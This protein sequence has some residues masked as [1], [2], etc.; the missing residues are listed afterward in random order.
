M[1]KIVDIELRGVPLK[2][3]VTQIEEC[4]CRLKEAVHRDVRELHGNLKQ[5]EKDI[6]AAKEEIRN[7][8]E[9]A[10]KETA[11]DWQGNSNWPFILRVAIDSISSILAKIVPRAF[12]LGVGGFYKDLAKLKGIAEVRESLREA[13][14]GSKERHFWE[15][16]WK[17]K[18]GDEVSW[19]TTHAT[20]A[21]WPSEEPSLFEGQQIKQIL[22]IQNEFLYGSLKADVE[23]E[24]QKAGTVDDA[25]SAFDRTL[26]RA[27]MY[28][29]SAWV[30]TNLGYENPAEDLLVQTG[31]EIWADFMGA[32]DSESCEGCKKAVDGSPY[33]LDEM[34]PIPGTLDCFGNCRHGLIMMDADEAKAIKAEKEA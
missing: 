34:T 1:S 10:K 31:E 32:Y 23:I 17:R 18:D 12:M 25:M 30:S 9:R 6:R 13:E 8:W 15:Y 26:K 22:R 29:E 5:V 27:Q 19:Q 16:R 24:L 11:D 14:A 7:I 21:N 3:A 33:R 28:A 4:L 20:N 2:E